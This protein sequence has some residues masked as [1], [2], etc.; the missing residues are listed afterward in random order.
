MGNLR[1]YMDII[2]EAEAADDLQPDPK[3][4][5]YLSKIL[6]QPMMDQQAVN[7]VEPLASPEITKIVSDL[8]AKN[9]G[10]D[11]RLELAQALDQMYQ[12]N[13]SAINQMSFK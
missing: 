11:I 10:Q 5:D 4:M 2:L 7:A 6:Q 1:Q 12:Q 9:P 13:V 3:I 8:V